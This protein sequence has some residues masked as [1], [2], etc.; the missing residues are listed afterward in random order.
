[1]T[2]LHTIAG[3]RSRP[4]EETI[5]KSM[6]TWRLFTQP[7][8]AEGIDPFKIDYQ[9]AVAGQIPSLN[10]PVVEAMLQ[11]RRWR[12]QVMHFI[13]GTQSLEA[14]DEKFILATASSYTADF[15]QDVQ[16]ARAID[17]LRSHYDYI[18]LDTPP[19]IGL[20]QRNALASADEI[21]IIGTFATDSIED[22]YR[23]DFFI[24]GIRRGVQRLGRTPP[25]VLGVLWNQMDNDE[26]DRKLLR[27][28]TEQHPAEDEYGEPTGYTEE[29]LVRH[30]SLGTVS[31]DHKTLKAANDKRRSI[32]IW[33][34]TSD[35]GRDL[36]VFV[37]TIDRV[38]SAVPAP[39][40]R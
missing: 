10:K 36:Y 8:L 28:Y 24:A 3:K 38:L 27:A 21:V 1:M 19:T 2:L 14:L 16:L 11:E 29:P 26:R 4:G 9:Q 31:F 35:I 20:V 15:Q 34:P 13:P 22:I 6:T 5:D 40:G 30:P 32:H 25:H 12:P 37:E 17:L 33:A 39:A 7:E 18:I 23:I